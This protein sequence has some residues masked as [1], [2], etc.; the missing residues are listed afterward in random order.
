[1]VTVDVAAQIIAHIYEVFS[2][3]KNIH[4]QL[5]MTC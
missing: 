5:K 2:I 3:T 1:L 4:D